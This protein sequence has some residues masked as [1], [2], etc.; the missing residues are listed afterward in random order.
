MLLF[1]QTAYPSGLFLFAGT[2]DIILRGLI[3]RRLSM[4][5]YNKWFQSSSGDR[6]WETP[7]PSKVSFIAK[8]ME[9]D[10]RNGLKSG[11]IV[12]VM[13][14]LA[15]I[16]GLY[17]LITGDRTSILLMILAL[18]VPIPSIVLFADAVIA[19][20]RYIDKS[21]ENRFVYRHVVVLQRRV[22]TKLTKYIFEVRLASTEDP[23]QTAVVQIEK[24]LYEKMTE[25]LAGLFIMIDDEPLRP[26]VSPFWFISDTDPKYYP[27][28]ASPEISSKTETAV[29]YSPS[30]EL[31]PA[32]ERKFRA[33]YCSYIPKA[34]L[35]LLLFFISSLCFLLGV[36]VS[37]DKSNAG[38]LSLLGLT[39]GMTGCIILSIDYIR[40]VFEGKKNRMLIWAVWLN[41]NVFGIFL[42]VLDKLS[43]G[44]RL[45][46]LFALFAINIASTWLAYKEDFNLHSKIRKGE[47]KILNGVVT[48]KNVIRKPVIPLWVNIYSVVVKGTDG[49]SYEI[50]IGSSQYKAYT[51][52]VRGTILILDS[53]PSRKF[54][55]KD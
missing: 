34:V 41:L 50:E 33:G 43:S 17:M 7:E 24:T 18:T 52:G 40:Q 20:K 29:S 16:Y 45:I 3:I 32:L 10:S 28:G 9:Q 31:K 8:K 5:G 49:N 19:T 37:S 54:F 13:M 25:G 51:E 48:G 2:V 11:I 1:R 46:A 42:I 22:T 27:S 30:E 4:A 35:L 36:L 26:L 15:F 47:Y 12:I 53:D 6:F 38:G 23:S 55:V 21:K 44:L 39:S 14:V